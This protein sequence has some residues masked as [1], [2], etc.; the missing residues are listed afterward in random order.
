MTANDPVLRTVLLVLAVIVAIPVFMMVFMIPIMGLGGWGHMSTGSGVGGTVLMVIPL[1]IL[2]GLGY[3][4]YIGASNDESP[5]M[6]GALEELRA[7]YA[8]GEL[9]DEEFERRRDRLQRN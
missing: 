8:R 2:A 7:A 3:L 1:L 6:D 9:S 4:L 5:G